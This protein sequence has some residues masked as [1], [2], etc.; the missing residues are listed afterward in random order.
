MTARTYDFLSLTSFNEAIDIW[1]NGSKTRKILTRSD[2]DTIKTILQN[3]EQ[4]IE[5]I[6]YRHWVRKNFVIQK[7]G[8]NDIVMKTS[9]HRPKKNKD[10][11]NARPLLVREELYQAFCETHLQNSHGG[12]NQTWNNVKKKWGYNFNYN[13][14]GNIYKISHL[15]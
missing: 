8:V 7:I 3:P 1:L 9:S 2:Y 6:N 4:K 11:D 14:L 10:D 13:M 12:L 5:S 15:K